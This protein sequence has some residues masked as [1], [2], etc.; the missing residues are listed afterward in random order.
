[1]YCK[2]SQNSFGG[3]GGGGGSGESGWV[4]GYD[5]GPDPVDLGQRIGGS[6]FQGL[7]GGKGAVR[8]LEG[9]CFWMFC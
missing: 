9:K 1:M 2:A 3:G 8:V 4:S 7:D 6:S 5:A